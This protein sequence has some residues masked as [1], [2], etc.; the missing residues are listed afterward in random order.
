[1]GREGAGAP[2]EDTQHGTDPGREA[3]GPT[4]SSLGKQLCAVMY[5]LLAWPPCPW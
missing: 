2:G 3:G 5:G 4:A 1:M